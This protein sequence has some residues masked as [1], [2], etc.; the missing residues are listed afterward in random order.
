MIENNCGYEYF[1]NTK[2]KIEYLKDGNFLID[3]KQKE[4]NRSIIYRYN[5]I[6]P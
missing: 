1:G 6:K 5:Q 2:Q 3:N 4:I